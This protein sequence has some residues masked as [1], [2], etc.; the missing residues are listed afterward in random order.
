MLEE[1][2]QGLG[3]GCTSG[4]LGSGREVVDPVLLLRGI[5][6]CPTSNRGLETESLDGIQKQAAEVIKG[7]VRRTGEAACKESGVS[8]LREDERAGFQGP[9]AQGWSVQKAQR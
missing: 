5:V 2:G 8:V 6:T 9:N 1:D 4:E 3:V 7:R